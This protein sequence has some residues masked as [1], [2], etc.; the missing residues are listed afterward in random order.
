MRS[1]FF[2]PSFSDGYSIVIEE[3]LHDFVVKFVTE[4]YRI[5]GA[6]LFDSENLLFVSVKVNGAFLLVFRNELYDI[7]VILVAVLVDT[8]FLKFRVGFVGAGVVRDTLDNILRDNNRV[9]LAGP[10]ESS[11]EDHFISINRE[12]KSF[13]GLST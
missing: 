2:S 11:C 3:F 4:E 7:E 9:R 6:Q 8:F 12:A 10:E 13:I 1:M 5:L